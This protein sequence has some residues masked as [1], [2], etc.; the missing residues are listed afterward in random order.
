M[1]RLVG[2]HHYL[3]YVD[4]VET[5]VSVSSM[6]SLAGS[7]IAVMQGAATLA[8][9]RGHGIYTA[10]MAARLADARAMGKDTA[11]LQGDRS[12]SAPICAKLG[13]E[14]VCSIDFYAWGGV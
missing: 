5:A 13:F 4:G 6:F 2:G 8:E 11:V 3:A 1:L 14:E 9:H 12:T 7:S 10:M